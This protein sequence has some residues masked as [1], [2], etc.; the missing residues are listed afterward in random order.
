[1]K[2][3]ISGGYEGS[4]CGS[5]TLGHIDFS[6]LMMPAELRG[7]SG[8]TSSKGCRFLKHAVIWSKWFI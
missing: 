4:N 6:T 5:D 7:D 2:E 8:K 3:D 1:M